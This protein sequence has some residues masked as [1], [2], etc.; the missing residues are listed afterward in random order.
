M[1]KAKPRSDHH[2]KTSQYEG[3]CC[4]C[5]AVVRGPGGSCDG[6]IKKG[7]TTNDGVK[8]EEHT[9]KNTEQTGSPRIKQ[10]RQ[11]V[12]HTRYVVSNTKK[13]KQYL[14]HNSVTFEAAAEVGSTS[15]PDKF[16]VLPTIYGRP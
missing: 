3:L 16:Y 8:Q 2:D 12:C 15:C 6:N 4:C 11:D 14:V 7:N 10:A 5:I 1:Q 13:E 9:K